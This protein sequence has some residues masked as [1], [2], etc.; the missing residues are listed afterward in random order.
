[1]RAPPGMPGERARSVHRGRIVVSFGRV[2]QAGELS[3]VATLCLTRHLFPP[4]VT[5]G[6]HTA[7][8][9]PG[10]LFDHPSAAPGK[11]S[12]CRLIRVELTG[13]AGLVLR[14]GSSRPWPSVASAEPLLAS[15][16]STTVGCRTYLSKSWLCWPPRHREGVRCADPV[17]GVELSF[18]TRPC[19]VVDGRGRP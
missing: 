15:Q 9:L 4:A 12:R 16:V 18:D 11:C 2:P 17:R 7:A 6:V 3:G 13:D 19:R 14:L 8:V 5:S 10:E 1:M